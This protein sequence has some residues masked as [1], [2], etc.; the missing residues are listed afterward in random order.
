MTEVSVRKIWSGCGKGLL[1]VTSSPV[2]WFPRPKLK[3][4][5]SSD[6]DE[7]TMRFLR[8]NYSSF[9]NPERASYSYKKA[10]L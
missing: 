5:K 3:C 4:F 2:N 6:Y 10:L 9:P 8:I 7:R 1:N